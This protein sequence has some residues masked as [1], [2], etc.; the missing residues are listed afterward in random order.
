MRFDP[1]PRSAGDNPPLSASLGFDPAEITIEEVAQDPSSP[2]GPGQIADT[3]GDVNLQELLAI[4]ENEA[5]IDTSPDITPQFEA[6]NR[7]PWLLL[8]FVV[9]LV[10]AAL[11]P[12]LRELRRRRRLERMRRGDVTAAWREIVDELADLGTPIPASATPIEAA[13]LVT[14]NMQ[15]LAEAY[16][17]QIYGPNDHVPKSLVTRAEASFGL[18]HRH[19]IDSHPPPK[20]L[21]RWLRIGS[22]R[23]R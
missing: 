1:T 22:L 14:P 21:W 9:A 3:V 20:R 4:L 19:L 8:F 6:P 16:Q 23:R 13:A 5:F 15:P 18:T 2:S 7:F 17:A 12:T 10:G 11:P